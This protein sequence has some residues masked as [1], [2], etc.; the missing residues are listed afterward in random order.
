MS[1][2]RP[3]LRE[4]AA[5]A[6]AALVLTGLTPVAAQAADTQTLAIDGVVRTFTYESGLETPDS[7]VV[8]AEGTYVPVPSNL[9]AGLTTA[10]PVTLKL[11]A[12]TSF[13][14]AQALGAAG[15]AAPGDVTVT[16]VVPRGPAP[17]APPT[18][19]GPQ[20]LLVLPVAWAAATDMQVS[21]LAYV[22]GYRAA[23][24]ATFWTSASAGG[25]T[26]ATDVRAPVRIAQPSSCDPAILR[27][28]ALAA[29]GITAPLDPSVHVVVY[30]Q[31]RVGCFVAASS[32]SGPEAVVN[33]SSS[34][35]VWAHAVGHTLGLDDT[36]TLRCPAS[37]ASVT[38]T[39]GCELSSSTGRD[40]M[41]SWAALSLATLAVSAPAAEALGWP[42]STPADPAQSLVL[43]LTVGS[44]ATPT[45]AVRVPLAD[46][47]ALY[48]EPEPQGVAVRRLLV[49]DDAIVSQRLHITTTAEFAFDAGAVLDVRDSDYAIAVL[50]RDS[51]GASV[52]VTPRSLD[53]AS[54]SAP[55][56]TAPASAGWVREQMLNPV[57]WTAAADAGTGVVGYR[58][59]TDG[60]PGAPRPA[61]TTSDTA[62]LSRGAHE[63]RVQAV[64]RAGNVSTS[65]PI[66]VS[67]GALPPAP[68]NVRADAGF[69]S[70]RVTWQPERAY[71]DAIGFDVTLT[72]GGTTFIAAG[73]SQPTL[74]DLAPGQ[75]TIA[76]SA[77]NAVGSSPATTT[78]FTVAPST[79]SVTA[80]P[81]GA[82]GSSP[83]RVRWTASPA[84]P[85][86]LAVVTL[87]G[88]PVRTVGPGVGELVLPAD[89]GRHSVVV[90]VVHPNGDEVSSAPV[91]VVVAPGAPLFRD[92]PADHPF[93]DEV[94][95][96]AQAG[97]TT[98]YADG[99][100]RPAAAI[101]RDAMAAFLYRYA[102]AD[103]AGY[104]PPMTPLFSDVPR[105]HP[106]YTEISWL[107]ET[108]ITTGYAD[109]T[110][111]PSGPVNRDAMAAFLYRF[112]HAGSYYEPPAQPLFDDVE[113]GHPFF[114]EISWMAE[115]AISTGWPDGSYRPRLPIARDA[116]AAFLYRFDH[117]V[118]PAAPTGT[119]RPV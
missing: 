116:M 117:P 63:F 65:A 82:A 54:P 2:R 90:T 98:G 75:Y 97:I 28:A 110:Y 48:V 31:D 39:G 68:A 4:S 45:T 23:S 58:L 79:V 7:V 43:P 84:V 16:E 55:V 41:D 105:S 18:V 106:F 107:A 9:A 17:V 5:A 76:V 8:D 118:A 29:H 102:G 99:T 44:G 34:D 14:L 22:A 81:V 112:D 72:P 70:V 26:M 52:A 73:A 42:R 49:R 104:E 3:R 13:S 25:M 62:S 95:W 67:A 100:Y 103:L 92:V 57:T 109:G 10:E 91:E 88:N 27:N 1:G 77:R 69:S 94:L 101:N 108:G 30:T 12:P 36:E 21:S 32:V 113:V 78:T 87:D 111:R 83:L 61:G 66:A 115:A 19:L 85:G 40:V 33:G 53:T 37:G 11:T 86:A 24:T 74:T 64:D 6:A 35:V 89:A 38:I 71:P 119:P 46:G 80:V 15:S 59:V 114:A 20:T 96:M 50:A 47:T 56:I 60:R 51:V 93:A